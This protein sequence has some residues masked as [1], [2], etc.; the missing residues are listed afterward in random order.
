M[1]IYLHR[2]THPCCCCCCCYSRSLNRPISSIDLRI[3]SHLIYPGGYLSLGANKAASAVVLVSR[4]LATAIRRPACRHHAGLMYITA[5]MSWKTSSA[6]R[7]FFG[8]ATAPPMDVRTIGTI[9]SGQKV[10]F[11]SVCGHVMLGLQLRFLMKVPVR[12]SCPHCLGA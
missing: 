7:F 3:R 4:H 11:A 6:N 1:T 10:L 5:C 9:V 2:A 12:S 8:R